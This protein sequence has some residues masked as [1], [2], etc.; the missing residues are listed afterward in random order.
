[1]A[2]Y[3]AENGLS[4]VGDLLAEVLPRNPLQNR[5]LGPRRGCTTPDE[6]R[7]LPFL[8]KQDLVADGLAHPP[9]GSNLTYPL[10]DYTRYHQT[11]GTTAAPLRVL[12][13]PRTWDWWGHC[14]LEVLRQ[15]GVTAADRL[16]FA[17]SFAPSIG[18]WSAHHGATFLGAL[19]IPAGGASTIQ[20]LRMILDTGATVL[21]GTPSYILHLAETARREGL[22][23]SDAQVRI[24]LHAGEPGASV[25]ATRQRIAEAWNAR[26]VDHAGATEIGAYG[27]GCPLGLGIHINEDEFVAEVLDLATD[28]PVADGMP[29]ELVLTGLGRGAWPAIRYRSGDIVRPRRG[30]CRCGSTRVLLEGGILGRADDMIIVRGLNLFPSAV[31]G[32][33]R[34]LTAAEFR[35]VATRQGEL[36]ELSVEL[37]GNSALADQ[38]SKCLREHLG[39]RVHVEAIADGTLPRP[40]GKARRFVDR[41]KPL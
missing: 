40:E 41:R 23:L 33:I 20:R 7:R 30:L 16:F 17:F 2:L 27:L 1:M 32:V 38:A 4:R 21:L 37:E 14:W 8:T 18:F 22:S 11:S 29:G 26:V 34:A 5:R 24:T 15:A 31:E 36:D 35:I 28:E 25:P 10:T 12:D 9:F 39:F 3:C 13:T 6:Y 19:C